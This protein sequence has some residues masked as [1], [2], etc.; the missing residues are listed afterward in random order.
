MGKSIKTLIDLKNRTV[1]QLKF[2]WG[3]GLLRFSKDDGQW[4]D[5]CEYQLYNDNGKRESELWT[6]S[7][8]ELVW[9]NIVNVEPTFILLQEVCK[10]KG[11]K[12]T[13]PKELKGIKQI[14]SVTFCKNKCS[15]YIVGN[16][17]YMLHNDYLAPFGH[18]LT[19]N[20]DLLLYQL[21]S[22]IILVV[23]KAR[24]SYM[25]TVGVVWLC[26]LSLGLNFKIICHYLN[27]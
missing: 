14:G 13:R 1:C 10:S 19:L 11:G 6:L 12:L 7:Q 20:I 17:I 18:P 5:L 22:I 15:V 2:P 3:W 8:P 27:I 24:N 21:L 9:N 23:I 16:D 26:R 25:M 4:L